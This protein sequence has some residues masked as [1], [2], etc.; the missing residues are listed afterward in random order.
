MGKIF[1]I[2]LAMTMEGLDSPLM[3]VAD[4]RDFAAWEGYEGWADHA[5]TVRLRYL[6]WHAAKRSGK[7]SVGWETFND[8][9]CIQVE[10]PDIEAE[11]ESEGEQGLDPG[12]KMPSAT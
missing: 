10:A 8:Q 2:R 4:Q 12:R 7:V 6:A 5:D 9:L 3:V 1:S 11:P